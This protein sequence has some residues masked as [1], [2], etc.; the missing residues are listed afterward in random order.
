MFF[1]GMALGI[2]AGAAFGIGIMCCV[3]AGKQE[4]QRME[5]I[6]IRRQKQGEPKQIQFRDME[7]IERFSL[8]DGESLCMMAE[9]GTKEI[10]ICRFVDEKQVD[11]NGQVWEIGE[12]LWQMERRGNSGV[13]LRDSRKEEK[14]GGR[15]R[16]RNHVVPVRLNAKELRHLDGQVAKSG[17]NREEFLRSLILGAQ[18][19]TKPCEHHAELLR[20]IA[21]L[22]NNANQLAHVANGTGMAGEA[23]VQEMIRISKETWRLVKEEW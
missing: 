6:R 20:K 17:L 19:Q 14:V 4:D 10:G 11:V 8:L 12:F 13:S 16:K 21:G 5:Q 22:C 9:D 15:M 7:G 18:L 2:V 3:V 23:S 1:A